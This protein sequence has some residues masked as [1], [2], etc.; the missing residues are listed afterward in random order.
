M[1]RQIAVSATM[2]VGDCVMLSTTDGCPNVTDG[3]E[4]PEVFRIA[5]VLAVET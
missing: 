4:I 1:S 5:I 3:A 2:I